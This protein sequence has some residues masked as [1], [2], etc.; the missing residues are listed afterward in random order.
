MTVGSPL[1][2]STSV[3]LLLGLVASVACG[4]RGCAKASNVDA[5][6]SLPVVAV[7]SSPAATTTVNDVLSLAQWVPSGFPEL[8]EQTGRPLSALPPLPPSG[9]AS[10]PQ[11]D[12]FNGLSALVDREGR[13]WLIYDAA[14]MA[15]PKIGVAQDLPRGLE[16]VD[17]VLDFAYFVKVGVGVQ[18]DGGFERTAD[19]HQMFVRAAKPIEGLQSAVGAVVHVCDDDSRWK[20]YVLDAQGRVM[21]WQEYA[22]LKTRCVDPESGYYVTEP[23]VG[24]PDERCPYQWVVSPVRRIEGLTY[25]GVVGRG[26]A[27]FRKVDDVYCA[28]PSGSFQKVKLPIPASEIG[29]LGNSRLPDSHLGVGQGRAPIGS[30]FS[31]EALDLASRKV[32]ARRRERQESMDW[33]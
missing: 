18:V 4:G 30:E 12:H 21:T 24:F 31:R 15:S 25:D 13:T 6:S 10:N 1:T 20:F 8:D 27:C 26:D 2:P 17:A 32:A 5:S 33:P 16:W 3:A 22:E 7:A 19:P 11:F 29:D 14:W 9:V 23:G 28:T